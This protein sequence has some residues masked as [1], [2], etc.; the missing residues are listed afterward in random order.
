M[1]T[2]LLFTL[3]DDEHKSNSEYQRTKKEETLANQTF[4]TGDSKD[5]LLCPELTYKSIIHK[6]NIFA[7]ILGS[8]NTT[9]FHLRWSVGE[10]TLAHFWKKVWSDFTIGPHSPRGT[11]LGLK[12]SF[13]LFFIYFIVFEE[14]GTNIILS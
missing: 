7:F 3:L 12:N 2:V 6:F 13:H 14:Q 4:N 8:N 1:Y 11:S 9:A 10:R 5:S